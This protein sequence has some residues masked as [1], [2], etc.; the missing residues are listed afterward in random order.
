MWMTPEYIA[1]VMLA[2]V[3]NDDTSSITTLGAS[4]HHIEGG[5]C[6][7]VL[8]GSVR[9]V[10]LLNNPGPPSTGREAEEAFD[11]ANEI[12]RELL[13]DLKRPGWGKLS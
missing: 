10:P 1:E 12:E 9:D 8:P 2:L 5:T 4:H 6:L 7:E 11:R 13:G 3:E